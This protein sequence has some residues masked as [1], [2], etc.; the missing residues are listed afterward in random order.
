MASRASLLVVDDYPDTLDVWTLSLRTAGYDVA[1]AADGLTAV[2]LAET[3]LPDLVVLDLEL[4]GR[5]GYDVAS[6]LRRNP[7]TR[8]IPLIAATGFSHEAQLERARRSGFDVIVIKPC[9]P[10]DL[11]AHIERLIR[12][13]PSEH[14]PAEER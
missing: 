6:M 11:I 13:A 8:H 1:T 2:T 7:A 4:P 12:S 5:S 14:P 10:A 9:D 3:L